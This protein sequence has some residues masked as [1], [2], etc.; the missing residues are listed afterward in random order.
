[1]PR[2]LTPADIAILQKL[3]PE[4]EGIGCP[5]S[6]HDFHSILPPLSN[7]IAVD[8]AD[9]RRRIRLLSADEWKYLT[10]LI[11]SGEESLG[12]LPEEEMDDITEC[13]AR[14]VSGASAQQ[15]RNLYYL[16]VC[17]VL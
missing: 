17:G 4:R 6:G 12:C 15:V 14:H 5:G 7:H 11:L 16:S 8:T 9:F 1:M 3:A 2:D 13:I 10:D